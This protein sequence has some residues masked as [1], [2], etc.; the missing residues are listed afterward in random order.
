MRV[1]YA[2]GFSEDERRQTRAIIFAN[3]L[4]AF[5]ALLDIMATEHI[6][7]STESAKVARPMKP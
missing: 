3:L 7:F 5:K 4:T 2:N 6:A 1:I